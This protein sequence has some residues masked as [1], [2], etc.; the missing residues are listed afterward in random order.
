MHY[1]VSIGYENYNFVFLLYSKTHDNYRIIDYSDGHLK[2][3]MQRSKIEV[4]LPVEIR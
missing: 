3:R 2:A 1:R 4:N